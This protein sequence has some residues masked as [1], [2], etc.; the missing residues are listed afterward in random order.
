[1]NP[2]I[3]PLAIA[4]G[5]WGASSLFHGVKKVNHKIA[6][7]VSE[8]FHRHQHKPSVQGQGNSSALPRPSNVDQ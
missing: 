1:M 5:L 4:L 8:P 3:V 7:V 6:H 2:Y